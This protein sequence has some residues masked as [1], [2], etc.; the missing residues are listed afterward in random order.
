M[1][2]NTISKNYHVLFQS[3]FF[4]LILL[5]PSSSFAQSSSMLVM[6]D[7]FE[8]DIRNDSNCKQQE[9]C[10]ERKMYFLEEGGEIRFNNIGSVNF[11]P[12]IKELPNQIPCNTILPNE[13]CSLILVKP[14]HFQVESSE[15]SQFLVD[16]FPLV[17]SV[18]AKNQASSVNQVFQNKIIEQQYHD[19]TIND[20]AGNEQIFVIKTGSVGEDIEIDNIYFDTMKN[21]IYVILKMHGEGVA[22]FE[23]ED[24]IFKTTK[25]A[26]VYQDGQYIFSATTF[27]NNYISKYSVMVPLISVSNFS[28]IEI[29]GDW[30]D[31]FTLY[32]TLPKEFSETNEDFAEKLKTMREKVQEKLEVAKEKGTITTCE[33]GMI[34]IDGNCVEKQQEVLIEEVDSDVEVFV[35]VDGEILSVSIISEKDNTDPNKQ[36][37]ILAKLTLMNSEEYSLIPLDEIDNNSDQFTSRGEVDETILNKPFEIT[38][39]GV[40]DSGIVLVG[41]E[42]DSAI[43]TQEDE[44]QPFCGAGTV[45]IDG[46]CVAESSGGGCLIATATYGS[47]LAPQVQQLRELRDTTLLQTQSGSAFMNGFNQLYYSFS[48]TIADYE[49]E[50]PIFKKAV[51]LTIT[52]LL[53]SLSILNYVNMDSEAEVLGYGISL[54]LLNVGMYIAVPIGIGIV[55]ARKSLTPFN[56]AKSL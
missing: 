30:V 11:T 28:I 55:I 45:L 5:I 9:D 46:V 16:G 52:P 4:G 56:F 14:G 18:Y 42:S 36:E 1:Q 19:I 40:S 54:I 15:N 49:R 27:P 53:T 23:I 7:F 35:D 13:S 29:Q 22:I 38:Y 44:S 33:S 8:V 37:R 2:L 26:V 3:I 43:V 20:S 39:K 24:T 47:E 34:S 12:V 6:S 48:P 21:S 31:E 32:D 25:Q 17:F 41:D 10:F 51:K 50:N